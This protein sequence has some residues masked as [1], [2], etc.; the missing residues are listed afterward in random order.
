MGNTCSCL[1][2]EEPQIINVEK[3]PNINT[4]NELIEYYLQ[5]EQVTLQSAPN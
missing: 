1:Y 2:E 3:M 5:L 4:I